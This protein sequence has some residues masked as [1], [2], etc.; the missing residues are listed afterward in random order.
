M[1]FLLRWDT[2]IKTVPAEKAKEVPV[3]ILGEMQKQG[4]VWSL[5]PQCPKPVTYVGTKIAG[6][7]FVNDYYVDEQGVY[8]HESR[9]P[10]EPVVL[11]FA[12]GSGTESR[13]CRK[14]TRTA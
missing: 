8:W 12:Y 6:H 4:Q 14:K 5:H 13:K 10:E 7:G 11:E 9:L 3:R 2:P 1:G